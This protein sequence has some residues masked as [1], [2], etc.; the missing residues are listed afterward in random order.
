MIAPR[1]QAI[2]RSGEQGLARPKNEPSCG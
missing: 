2:S 1:F